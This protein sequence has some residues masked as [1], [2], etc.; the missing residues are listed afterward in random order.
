MDGNQ[1]NNNEIKNNERKGRGLFYGIVAV[2]TF[3]IM[4]V[5]A[6]FAYFAAT[7]A[8]ANTSITTGSTSL[9]LSLLSY[10]TAW[11]KSDL[12]P[13][14]TY[15]VKYA[16]ANQD[17]TTAS[18]KVCYNANSEVVEC[19]S[20]D[21]DPT[22]TIVSSKSECYNT[23]GESVSCDSGDVDETKTQIIKDLNNTMCVDDYG[24]SVC[25]VYVFQIINDNASPQ[26]MTFSIISQ[27]NTFSNLRAMAYEISIGDTDAYNSLNDNNQDGDPNVFTVKNGNTVLDDADYTPIYVN[28]KGVSK[29]LLSYTSGDITEDAVDKALTHV[30]EKEASD[31]NMSM[32][33]TVVA[34]KV[35]IDSN[36]TKTFAIVLY[37]HN[38]TT[39]QPDDENDVFQGA[40]NV[41]TGDGTTGVSGYIRAAGA[42]EGTGA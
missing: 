15:I 14:D 37:I 9:S 39:A 10:E 26:T 7:A 24:N 1:M 30:E 16:F 32:R 42:A 40:I 12:I 35:D 23:A 29:R 25:S 38:L 21:V 41:T 5:G 36:E 19:S 4:A 18:K 33:T 8:S 2:A 6:T 28:R 22:K 13:V 34:N 27:L 17:D 20:S 3:I 31:E 11:S